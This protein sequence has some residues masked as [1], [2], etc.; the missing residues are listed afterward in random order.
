MDG[1][2]AYNLLEKLAFTRVGGSAEELK[3][4]QII[5]DEIKSAN[6]EGEIVPFDV[7]SSKIKK[8]SLVTSNGNSY[9]VSGWLV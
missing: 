8:A 9:E 7:K 5:L 4:A 3:A 1:K 2:R 6:G